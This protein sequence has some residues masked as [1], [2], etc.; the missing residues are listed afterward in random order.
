[1][2]AR[3]L[4]VHRQIPV[5]N[6]LSDNLSIP[7]A[8]FLTRPLCKNT[9]FADV[10]VGGL[11]KI[12]TCAPVS[13]KYYRNSDK[14]RYGTF[15]ESNID[16]RYI[17]MSAAFKLL[18]HQSQDSQTVKL[19]IYAHLVFC[20]E[21]NRRRSYTQFNYTVGGPCINISSDVSIYKA[22]GSRL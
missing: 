20:I 17:N 14:R 16:A 2:T 18:L 9:P 21:L 12:K 13:P 11:T 4:R 22:A 5:E 10:S 6:M 19:S 7:R 1:M 8:S 15:S 3:R